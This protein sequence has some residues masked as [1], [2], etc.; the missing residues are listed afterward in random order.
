MGK[1]DKW[2]KVAGESWQ[3]SVDELKACIKGERKRTAHKA[4]TAALGHISDH[5]VRCALGKAAAE[6]T[7]PTDMRTTIAY[8][9]DRRGVSALTPDMLKALGLLDSLSKAARDSDTNEDMFT[10]ADTGLAEGGEQVPRRPA[11]RAA[12]RRYAATG[13]SGGADQTG[14]PEGIGAGREHHAQRHPEDSY[15]TGGQLIGALGA[16]DEIE[17]RMGARR[18]PIFARSVSTV[19]RAAMNT[20]AEGDAGAGMVASDSGG[21]YSWWSIATA[22]TNHAGLG[23]ILRA[24]PA[25]VNAGRLSLT[26]ATMY[27]TRAERG[28]PLPEGVLRALFDERR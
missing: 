19:Q 12:G 23:D 11:G 25:A 16:P 5:A 10:D 27:G 24:L 3:K 28:A 20:T 6:G 21:Q 18:Q 9:L 15:L 22:R 4:A 13:V 14:T 1:A 17:S 26:D 8:L 2:E 7:V